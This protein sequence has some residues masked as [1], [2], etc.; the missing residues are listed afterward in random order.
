MNWFGHQYPYSGNAYVGLVGYSQAFFG[1]EYVGI[2]LSNILVAGQIY[3]VAIN[4]SLADTALYAIKNIGA[5]FTNTVFNPPS[6][7]VSSIPQIENTGA[8]ITDK[9]NWVTI[10]GSF[11][12]V[13]DEQYITIGNFRNDANTVKQF[14]GNGNPS[15]TVAYYYIDDVYVGETPLTIDEK[16]KECEVKLFPNPA[17]AIVTI[18]F[19]NKNVAAYTFEITNLLGQLQSANAEIKNN[20]ISI[21]T[22]ALPMGIYFV[23]LVNKEDNTVV[24][25][26]VV[27]SPS[28]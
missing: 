18:A 14:V 28:P 6:S 17:N 1:R 26:K 2:Q 23:K 4:V 12:A 7:S 27:R 19:K 9:T 16:E 25:R 11:V 5:L 20:T 8:V 15:S 13:G 10:S 24:V 22:E 3:Y 21:N